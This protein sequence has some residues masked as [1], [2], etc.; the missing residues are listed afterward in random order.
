MPRAYLTT[1]GAGTWTV[2]PG[3]TSVTVNLWSAA[4]HGT[5][6]FSPGGFAGG[7]QG[8]GGGQWARRTINTTPGDVLNYHV[9]IA[10]GSAAT[11]P[12]T[13]A[14]TTDGDSWFGDPTTTGVFA[15]GAYYTQPN[16]VSRGGDYHPPG[17]GLGGT[18]P[19]PWEW[20]DGGNVENVNAASSGSGGGG[21]GGP[22]GAGGIGRY[23]GGLWEGAG[24]GGAANGGTD[25]NHNSGGG[26]F[27]GLYGGAGG[28][29]R[30]SAGSGAGSVSLGAAASAGTA[31]G[32]GGGGYGQGFGDGRGSAGG[33][34]STDNI[35]DGI[36][37]PGSGGG[38][39][40]GGEA[41]IG[42]GG[43]VAGAGGN[44]GQFGGG[45]GGSATTSGPVG[46]G[47]QGLIVI[48]YTQ[49]AARGHV[50]TRYRRV[51]LK[52]GTALPPVPPTSPANTGSPVMNQARVGSLSTCSPGTWTGTA[53]ITYAYQWKL[54]GSPITGQTSST[55]TPVSGDNGHSL[56]CTVTATNVAGSTP[57]SSNAITVSTTSGPSIDIPDSAALY[58]AAAAWPTTGDMTWRLTGTDYG[59]LGAYNTWRFDSAPVVIDGL[60]TAQFEWCE[61]AGASGFTFQNMAN[62]YGINPS[63]GAAMWV[64]SDNVTVCNLTFTNVPIISADAMGTQ[65]QAGWILRNL[66]GSTIT[67]NGQNDKALPDMWGC[68]YGI[69]MLTVGL[70]GA[71]HI[72]GM[73]FDNM[74]INSIL[75][76][77]AVN[78]TINSCLFMNNFY[79]IG[80]HPNAIHFFGDGT[81][82][83]QNITCTNN[84]VWQGL[85][86]GGPAGFFRES[87]T[88]GFYQNNWILSGG[89]NN[90]FSNARGS[91]ETVDNNFAQ[92]T[93][94]AGG[95]IITR[96]AAVNTTVTNSTACAIANY[97]ADGVNPGYVPATLP[98]TNTIIPAAASVTDYT[99]LDPWLA[100]HPTARARV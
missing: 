35:G 86:G 44:G 75:S 96:G 93:G 20:S 17:S 68:T 50:Y 25:G 43:G 94:G 48:D 26:G 41:A 87:V 99:Y 40:G 63:S 84:G 4:T 91:D 59:T 38:G 60:G 52:T 39:G 78:V 23:G 67:I 97:P 58:A 89:Q 24:G 5:N 15:R 19:F 11:G 74:G 70:G 37:G 32:G 64:H 34:G 62:I 12:G 80:D 88:T 30:L 53:P 18:A 22:N 49:E 33:D 29:N 42:G 98:G 31:G 83:S 65:T 79:G 3:V 92:G 82:E 95:V 7:G 90:A 21:A 71:V 76:G 56:S 6:E 73:T 13:P 2:L 27:S 81:R 28:N 77:G 85:Y 57:Q 47:G 54:D 8:G 14:A 72:N 46:Q 9:G 16:N 100:A 61:M 36:Y 45:G 69:S 1:P 10:N 51:R 55:Y 66:D